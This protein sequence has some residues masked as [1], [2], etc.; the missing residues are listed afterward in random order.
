MSVTKTQLVSLPFGKEEMFSCEMATEN[1]VACQTGPRATTRLQEKLIARL[2]SPIDLPSLENCLLPEDLVALALE[3]HTPCA[4]DLIAGIWTV[5]NECGVPADHITIVQTFD[6]IPETPPDDP[7]CL[8]PEEI[9]EV[10][11]WKLHIP[12]D[13]ESCAYIATTSSGERV[14]LAREIV[15]ADFVMTVGQIAFNSVIGF[16]GTNSVFYPGLSTKEALQKSLG[17]GHLELGP[18]EIRPLRQKVDEIGWLLGTLFSVQVIPSAGGGVYHL[19]AGNMDSVMKQGKELLSQ[20]WLI[21]LPKRPETLLLA[22]DEG[23]AGEGWRQIGAA[24]A[25][26]RRL[27]NRGGRVILLTTHSE[28]ISSGVALLQQSETPSK[29]LKKLRKE[30]PS[31]LIAASQIAQ[32]AEWAD[33]YLLSNL[34]NDLVE[35]LFFIPLD[36]VSDAVRLLT[37]A[38]NTLFLS[39]AQHTFGCIE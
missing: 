3:P 15:E 25:S 17:Q 23:V 22:I 7:R 16:S 30:L 28:P 33:I 11:K 37:Q 6:P 8:L 36:N 10:I 5:L 14:Y 24:L 13:E 26:A 18:E 34:P 38:D 19:L 2:R 32:A 1:V 29:A 31:D 9:R 12:A 35:N 27:V 39:S 4:P 20:H 21:N